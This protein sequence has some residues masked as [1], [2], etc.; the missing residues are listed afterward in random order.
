MAKRAPQDIKGA[1]KIVINRSLGA[2]RVRAPI[3]DGT[4]Q[5]NPTISGTKDLPGNLALALIYPSRKAARAI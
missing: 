2:S 3:M 4:L 1:I 5:P